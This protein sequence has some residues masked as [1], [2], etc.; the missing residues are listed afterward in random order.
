MELE[1]GPVG[2]KCRL[3]SELRTWTWLS[4]RESTENAEDGALQINGRRSPEKTLRS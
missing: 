1:N 4:E 3:Q 2:V